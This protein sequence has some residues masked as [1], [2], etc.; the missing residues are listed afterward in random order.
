[1]HQLQLSP[2]RVVYLQCL[3]VDFTRKDCWWCLGENRPGAMGTFVMNRMTQS[4]V[5]S[6]FKNN[7][8]ETVLGIKNQKSTEKR[9][10]KKKKTKKRRTRKQDKKPQNN[11]TTSCCGTTI[12][13]LLYL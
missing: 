2:N 4:T 13:S 3:Y 8:E 11:P 10:Q 7:L 1:M 6:F 5:S 12:D 9:K